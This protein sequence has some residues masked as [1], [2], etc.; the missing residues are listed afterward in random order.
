MIR[1]PPRSTL[2][3]YTTL[4]RSVPKGSV[5]FKDAL[6]FFNDRERSLTDQVFTIERQLKDIG[7][8]AEQYPYLEDSV[9]TLTQARDQ[10]A[11]VMADIDAWSGEERLTAGL[12]DWVTRLVDGVVPKSVLAPAKAH[13]QDGRDMAVLVYENVSQ[14]LDAAMAAA[15]SFASGNLSHEDR[16]IVHLNEIARWMPKPGALGFPAFKTR[17]DALVRLLDQV[18]GRKPYAKPRIEEALQPITSVQ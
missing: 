15:H 2:F 11:P 3:P 7:Y 16:I 10:L 9:A 12:I 6:R 18:V 17:V 4:F 14:H 5:E 8:T 13:V 1:R